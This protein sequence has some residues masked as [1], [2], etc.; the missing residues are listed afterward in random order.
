MIEPVAA[1]RDPEKHFALLLYA[2][3]Y[4]AASVRRAGGEADRYR[5]HG[6]AL[7]TLGRVRASGVR[8]TVVQVQSD[9]PYDRLGDDGIRYLG[10]GTTSMTESAAQVGAYLGDEAVTHVMLRFPSSEMLDEITSR[11]VRVS[12][13][14][15]D[16]FPSRARHW[17]RHR[18]L[19][20]RLRHPSIDFVANHHLNSSRQLVEVIGLDGT[21]VVP[22]DW[23][24]DLVDVAR[25][26]GRTRRSGGTVRLAY[27]GLL[28]QSKGVWDVL[29]ATALLRGRGVEVS[30]EVAGAGQVEEMWSHV[31]RLGL[32]PHVS[33]LGRV[34]GDE[35]LDVMR[36]SDF[37]CVPSRPAYPEGLPLT[38]Y[39]AM[40]SGTPVVA[41]DHPMFAGV[42]RDGETGFVFRAGKPARLAETLQRAASDGEA[43]ARVS[44][45]AALAYEQLG[46]DTLWGELVERWVRDDEDDRGW[47]ATRSLSARGATGP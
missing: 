18:R 9:A 37:V 22:W 16:S 41:S 34:G 4:S 13:V 25:T 15:A 30:L 32:R 1:R 20:R 28:Q 27:V 2:G 33:Y 10:L 47:L 40:A 36:R 24:L 45:H 43:Y 39:E 42:V 5:H 26:A 46:L 19:G 6:Y 11:P 38:L 3:D 35:I 29:E 21:R 8:V 12:V 14:L 7:D 44:A 31:D 17:W 23:P